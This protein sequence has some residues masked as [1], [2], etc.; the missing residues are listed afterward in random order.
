MTDAEYEQQLDAAISCAHDSGDEDLE[1]VLREA[2]R[3]RGEEKLQMG[4]DL[5]L[6]SSCWTKLRPRLM[7]RS[8]TTTISTRSLK[9]EGCL[10]P[11]R[12]QRGVAPVHISG[13]EL[14]CMT[15]FD[16]H[17]WIPGWIP[18]ALTNFWRSAT[19]DPMWYCHKRERS[20]QGQRGFDPGGN[21]RV[22]VHARSRRLVGFP[23]GAWRVR[24]PLRVGGGMDFGG[25]CTVKGSSPS[26]WAE[27]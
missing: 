1:A 4:F 16:A 2:D 14:G 3:R 9:S 27:W 26:V 5:L 15:T 20:S 12:A 25:R 7:P 6:P 23:P 13:R 17:R 11:C 19:P 8:S 21:F 24:A 18:G 22:R 10:G